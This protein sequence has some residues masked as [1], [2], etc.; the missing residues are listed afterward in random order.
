MAQ[1]VLAEQK[2]LL[3]VEIGERDGESKLPLLQSTPLFMGNISEIMTA[4]GIM[5]LAQSGPGPHCDGGDTK[6][7]ACRDE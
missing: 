4:T 3:P 7:H 5:K 1:M 2:L 6:R